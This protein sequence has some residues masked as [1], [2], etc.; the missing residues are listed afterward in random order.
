MLEINAFYALYGPDDRGLLLRPLAAASR[1]NLLPLLRHSYYN[2]AV[3]SETQEII[4]DDTWFGAA[5]FAITCADYDDAGETPD[6]KAAAILAEAKAFAPSAPR[7]LRTYYSERLICAFWP[8]HGPL[9][10]PEPFAGGDYPT[11]VLNSDT[12]PITSAKMAYSVFD[13]VQ[14]GSMVIMQGGPHV[15]WGRGLAC[16]DQIVFDLIVDNVP[17]LAPV[18]LCRQ[19]FVTGYEPLT[20]TNPNDASQP[21]EI[22]RALERELAWSPELYLW[23]GQDPM[24]VGCDYGGYLIVSAQDAGTDYSFTDCQFWKGTILNGTGWLAENDADDDGMTLYLTVSGTHQGQFTYHN[25]YVTEA[26]KLT[27][28]FNGSDVSTPRPLP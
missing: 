16:P 24:G 17:P 12:D 1:G 22:A 8:H 25:N 28:F 15:I 27:G 9:Q 21:I 26:S 23:N 4:P 5:Y 11:L 10:R 18:Q 3:D 20:M 13:H 14:N 19:E 6:A 7:L 2:L